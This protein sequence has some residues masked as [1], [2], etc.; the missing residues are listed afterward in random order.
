MPRSRL[1]DGRDAVLPDVGG[2]EVGQVRLGPAGGPEAHQ[3][4]V[5]L[6]ALVDVDPLRVE[7]VR[8]LREVEAPRRP[9]GQP[10]DV[11][12]RREVAVPVVRVDA[13]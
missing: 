9:P 2:A 8:R 6:P 10:V 4:L 12:G 11:R 5:G 1:L 13:E 7:Q 3:V